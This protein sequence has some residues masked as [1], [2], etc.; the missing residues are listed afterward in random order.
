M[1]ASSLPSDSLIERPRRPGPVV[2]AIRAMVNTTGT[3]LIATATLGHSYFRAPFDLEF[4]ELPMPLS[5]LDPAFEGFRIVHLSDF[6]TGHGTPVEYLKRA[7]E[8]V[9]QM[10]YDLAVFTGDFVTHRLAN[11]PEACEIIGM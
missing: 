3:A 11:V 5:G 1:S 7:I 9:N 10:P 6:H 2:S 8:R 4:V